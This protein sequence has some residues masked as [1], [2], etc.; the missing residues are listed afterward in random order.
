MGGV[1]RK[2]SRSWLAKGINPFQFFIYKYNIFIYISYITFVFLNKHNFLSTRI[3]EL[4]N[5]DIIRIRGLWGHFQTRV[6]EVKR[7]LRGAAKGPTTIWAHMVPLPT[8]NLWVLFFFASF[9]P[10][11]FFSY[12]SFSLTKLNSIVLSLI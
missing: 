7:G 4:K 8:W 12:A 1:K 5:S 3:I 11:L 10:S 9:F 6:L 2:E